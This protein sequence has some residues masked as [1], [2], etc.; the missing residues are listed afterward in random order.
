MA[1]REQFKVKIRGKEEVLLEFENSDHEIHFD[2][3]LEM[4]VCLRHR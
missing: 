4:K 1:A 2:K 3:L